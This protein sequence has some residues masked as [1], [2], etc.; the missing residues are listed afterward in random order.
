MELGT[1]DHTKNI[2]IGDFQLSLPLPLGPRGNDMRAKTK[3]G[4]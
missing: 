3:D 1:V 2:F 4:R